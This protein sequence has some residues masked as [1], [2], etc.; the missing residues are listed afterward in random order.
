MAKPMPTLPPEGERIWLLMPI[1]LPRMSNIGPPEL[2]WLIEA[3]VWMNLSYVPPVPR[4]TAEMLPAVTVPD[5]AQGLPMAITQ[6]P[7][8]ALD[9]GRAACREGVGQ[10]GE[11]TGGG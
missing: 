10:Y 2:P 4:C 3:S 11:N 8:L 9:T 5:R 1:T 6:S 7:T